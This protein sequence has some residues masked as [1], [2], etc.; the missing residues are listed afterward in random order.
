MVDGATPYRLWANKAPFPSPIPVCPAQYT[1]RCALLKG[2][3][4]RSGFDDIR[5]YQ[6]DFRSGLHYPNHLLQSIAPM[7]VIRIGAS[8][9]FT[10]SNFDTT[11]PGAIDTFPLL[12]S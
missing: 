5:I 10:H 9:I 3:I 2:L 1:D 11:I 12:G 6:I 4:G 7:T 8:N